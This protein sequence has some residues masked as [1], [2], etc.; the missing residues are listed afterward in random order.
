MTM[1]SSFEISELP[2]EAQEWAA[3]N[4]IDEAAKRKESSCPFTPEDLVKRAK[5]ILA[6]NLGFVGDAG[7]MLAE[8]FEF[9]GPV[10]GPLN[11][12]E[13]IAA[14]AGFDF[15]AVFPDSVF[16]FY[17]FRVDAFDPYRVFFTSRG[18]G[19]QSEPA[20]NLGIMKATGKKYVNPPQTCSLK[21]NDEG[22]AIEYTIGYVMNR[23]EGNTGG[24]GGIYG[25]LYAIGKPFPFPEAQ[26]RKKSWQLKVFQAVTGLAQRLQSKKK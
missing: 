16:E 5:Y 24:L 7:D 2:K 19:T 17:D 4:F 14:I 21:F 20:P 9:A 10:V 13:Y 26:P 3:T 12:K 15:M 6:A 11:K 1:R 8:D 23:R 22:K 18:K 25:I